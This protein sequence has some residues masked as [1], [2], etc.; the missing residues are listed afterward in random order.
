MK[1]DKGSKY[2]SFFAV[3]CGILTSVLI[4]AAVFFI[5]AGIMTFTGGLNEKTVFITVYITCLAAVLAG[6]LEAALKTGE[7]GLIN[8]IM[9]AFCYVIIMVMAG[10]I[11]LP[12]FA[13]GLKTLV[14]L[15]V[16]SMGGAVGG[17]LGVNLKK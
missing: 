16:S 4:S 10:Y 15:A 8:G 17:I 7:R 11:F 1:R 6:S 2:S 5:T 9:V 3:F 12:D 13:L 14:T